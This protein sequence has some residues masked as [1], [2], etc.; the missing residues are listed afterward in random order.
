M[1]P[2][3]PAARHCAL[4][5]LLAALLLGPGCS[6]YM[7]SQ[8]P[9]PVDLSSFKPDM[10]RMQ[11]VSRLGT[12]TA[13]I[14][15]NGQSC[16]VFRVY[17]GP[18]GAAGRAAVMLLEGAAAV[19]TLGL[20]EVVLAPAEAVTRTELTPVAFCY[21]AESQLASVSV[22]QQ[23]AAPAQQQASAAPG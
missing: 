10:P 7:Q 1:P 16:D 17:T 15:H 18:H 13:T 22:V 12:P 6:V 5:A 9:D 14:A 4:T 21:D 2:S 8:R 23:P 3:R 11:V 19:F 20:S